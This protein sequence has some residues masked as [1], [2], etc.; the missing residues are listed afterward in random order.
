MDSKNRMAVDKVGVISG[1]SQKVCVRGLPQGLS[2][3]TQHCS[4]H[5][6]LILYFL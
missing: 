4:A 3:G 1:L 6:N 2:G 5:A